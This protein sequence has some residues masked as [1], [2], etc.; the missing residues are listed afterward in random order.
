MI[1]LSRQSQRQDQPQQYHADDE[2]DE[3][4]ESQQQHQ[5]FISN[6]RNAIGSSQSQH[7][8]HGTTSQE[9]EEEEGWTRM[10]SQQ[11]ATDGT[12]REEAEDILEH[13]EE[14]ERDSHA[15]A[16]PNQSNANA[17]A[18]PDLL[19]PDE[20]IHRI[21]QLTQSVVEALAEPKLP[22]LRAF[23]E[24]ND[25]EDEDSSDSSSSS[26][27]DSDDEH[28]QKV[29]DRLRAA[30][31]NNSDSNN[32]KRFVFHNLQQ[33]R[34]FSSVLLVLS[35]CHSLLLA[36]R[37]TTTREV[38]YFYVTHFRSQKECDAAIVEAA[39][40]LGVP[41]SSLGLYASPKGWFCGCLQIIRNGRVVLDG[42][43]LSSMQGAPITSEWLT[44]PQQRDFTID[45][46]VQRNNDTNN[47]NENN[48]NE[49]HQRAKCILVIEKEGVYNRFSEDRL[50][51][52]YPCILVTGK[53]FPDLATRSLVHSLHHELHLPVYGLA[54]C[55]PYGMMVLQTYQYGSERRGLD[56]GAR[57]SVPLQWLGLRPSQVERIAE[58]N[59]SSRL[60]PGIYQQLTALDQR[61]LEL[62][63]DENHK[64][65]GSDTNK[66]RYEEL[67]IMQENDYKVEL[68]AM[69]WLGMDYLTNWVYET[70]TRH[71]EQL[72]AK[73]QQQQ[74]GESDSN[75]MDNDEDG[76]D[77]GQEEEDH[78]D[79]SSLPP[80]PEII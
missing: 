21:E 59:N 32:G 45:C 40:L 54:D 72:L 4:E 8:D 79:A 24:C 28:E 65:H 27:S 64:F 1:S 29:L 53:G 15:L 22:E 6:L 36:R 46:L 47:A 16:V 51:E 35:F 33:C 11:Q 30:Q 10:M 43:N 20:V 74:E 55:N 13:S 57:Y 31:N 18:L 76:R 62:M 38:Y 71:D 2:W 48:P 80:M 34:V 56:G 17:A 12:Q 3:Q 63:L 39:N 60:P 67:E 58:E 23:V 77:K 70:L 41:R 25:N 68:E 42:Q 52:R 7:G 44:P 66:Y 50:Y 19:S 5:L 73:Q 49:P 37:T 69:N 9:E 75:S 78:S 26:T 14:Q 61:R